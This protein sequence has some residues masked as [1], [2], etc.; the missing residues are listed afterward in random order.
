MISHSNLKQYVKALFDVTHQENLDDQ[1]ILDLET[2][3]KKINSDQNLRENLKDPSKNFQQ[4]KEILKKIFADFISHYT[5]N[6]LYL[7]LKKNNINLLSHAIYHFKKEARRKK[8][9][10][11]V[12]VISAVKLNDQTKQIISQKITQKTGKKINLRLKI[13]PEILG[14]LIIQTDD[15]LIDASIKG[16]VDKLRQKILQ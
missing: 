15:R 16:R 2:V 11:E 1:V 9:I 12:S 6:F 14:G 10:I 5:Y 7:L 13:Q 3:L 4:K 8:G